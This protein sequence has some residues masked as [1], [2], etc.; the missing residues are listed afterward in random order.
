MSRKAPQP[1]SRRG[2]RNGF[3]VQRDACEHLPKGSS[4]AGAQHRVGGSTTGKDN[5]GGTAW[6]KPDDSFKKQERDGDLCP[7]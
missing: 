7:G 4:L 5:A 6:L 2:H 1:A 3:S